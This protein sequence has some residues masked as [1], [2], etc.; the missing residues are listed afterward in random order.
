MRYEMGNKDLKPEHSWQLDFGLDY[1]SSIAS[2]QLALFANRIS[3]YI[4]IQKLSD[5]KGCE[6]MIDDTPAYQF[7][8]S[9]A[10][11][12]GG[13]ARV[14][15][16]PLP[17]LH[18]GNSFSYVNAVLLHQ[19]AASKYLPL[20]PAPR[21]CG[22]VK[23]EFICGGST[24]DNLFLKFAVD[25]NLRQNHFYAA[26]NTETATPSFTLLH[27]YAGADIK[28]HGK[29]RLS[30]YLS[31]ENL[32]NRAYQSH[33]SRLKYL[34]KNVVTGRTG[35]YNMGRNFSVKVVVPIDL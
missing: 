14:D 5:E 34:D 8:A 7:A 20:T 17:R 13:E 9:S 27:L 32:T 25:C 19:P 29:R 16:H 15:I 35:V 4:F 1:S 26:N 12:L 18:I 30:I 11:L 23:Y 3:N 6:I 24:F 33:L 2:A 22:D 10:R 21:W 28:S 31:A